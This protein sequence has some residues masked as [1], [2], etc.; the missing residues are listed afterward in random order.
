LANGL[1]RGPHYAAADTVSQGADCEVSRQCP[2]PVAL[3]P[4]S[5][6]RIADVMG[7]A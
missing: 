7:L 2:L 3:P 6:L 1:P 4:L 5:A